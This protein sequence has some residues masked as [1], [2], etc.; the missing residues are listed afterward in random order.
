LD[1]GSI[2]ILQ[3]VLPA[4]PGQSHGGVSSRVLR[5]IC[6]PS[7]LRSI[8]HFPLP[9]PTNS[10]AIIVCPGTSALPAA[11]LGLLKTDETE[12]FSHFQV[13]RQPGIIRPHSGLSLRLIADPSKVPLARAD[14]SDYP[15]RV[16]AF[17]VERFLQKVITPDRLISQ[18][19][20]MRFLLL[21]PQSRRKARTER[22]GISVSCG[23]TAPDFAPTCCILAYEGFLA[24]ILRF[25]ESD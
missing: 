23:L 16:K 5:S 9:S 19:A 8:P 6:A 10:L 3:N 12:E 11:I 21:R 20:S 22:V 4:S 17:D 13:A 18:R 15:R 24:A 25:N 7:R 2:R 1:R 14:D